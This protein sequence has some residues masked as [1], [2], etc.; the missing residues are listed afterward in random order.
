M[1]RSACSATRRRAPASRARCTRTRRCARRPSSARATSTRRRRSCRSNRPTYE[2]LARLNVSRADAATKHYVEK[3]L[4]DF[5]RA[6]VDKDDATRARIKTL[7]E[8][9]VKLGQEFNSNIATDVRMI[10]VDPSDLDGL[11]DDFKRAHPG[12]LA[13]ARC[14]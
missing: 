5:K 7:R 12:P 8:E 3:T 13:T 1:P 14:C 2:A 9:L 4:R 11:P 6:G 10:E